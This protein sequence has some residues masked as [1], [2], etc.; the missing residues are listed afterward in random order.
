MDQTVFVTGADKGLGRSLVAKFLHEGFRVFAGQFAD[1]ANL[2]HLVDQFSDGLVT[3]LLDVTD[4]DSVRQTA[5]A[6]SGQ[7]AA[8]DV[9]INNAGVHLEDTETP[10][11][12]LDLTDHHLQRTMEVNAFGPLRMTQ[13]FLPLLQKGQRKLIVNISSEAGSIADCQRQREYAY[14]MSKAALNMQSKI[15]QNHLGP[16][17]FKVLAVHPGWMQTDMGGSDADIHPDVAAE[18]IFEL[19]ARDWSSDDTLYLDYRGNPMRW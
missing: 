3:V 2:Q 18:G 16:R 9:L 7:A 13:Q 10:L 8:L 14:C 15:L 4:M 17:G 11:E 5:S 12:Q 1:G 19:V 6:V